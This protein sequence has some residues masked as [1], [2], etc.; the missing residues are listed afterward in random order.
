M[1]RQIQA[2]FKNTCLNRNTLTN[3]CINTFSTRLIMSGHEGILVFV[4]DLWTLHNLIYK[5]LQS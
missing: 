3:I 5:V 2:C 4:L 1:L